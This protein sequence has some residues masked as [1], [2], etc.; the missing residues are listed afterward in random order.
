M[1]ISVIL[2]IISTPFNNKNDLYINGYNITSDKWIVITASN[3]PTND[4][5]NLE[6]EINQEKI[7]VI[8]NKKTID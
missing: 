7:V 1:L 8:G 3:P 6:R 4:I 5:I 2:I